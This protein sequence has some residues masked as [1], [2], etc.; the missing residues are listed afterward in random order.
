MCF[1]AKCIVDMPQLLL[2]NF[3]LTLKKKEQF[4]Y[5][6]VTFYMRGKY[7]NKKGTGAEWHVQT[8]I[9]NALI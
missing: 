7:L 2:N 9:M 3:G 1:D 4:V 6:K 8:R 5:Q